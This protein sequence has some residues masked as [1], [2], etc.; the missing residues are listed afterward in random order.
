MLRMAVLLGCVGL[1]F[2]WAGVA[3]ART[4]KCTTGTITISDTN[5][6]T[7]GQ[8]CGGSVTIPAG[9]TSIND[10]AFDTAEMLK[11]VIIP[12]SVTTVG[13][14][15]FNGAKLLTGVTFEFPSAVTSIGA[16]AFAYTDLTSI[17]IPDS[18]K[19][20]G[21]ATFARSGSLRS[22]YFEGNAPRLTNGSIFLDNSNVMVYRFSRATGFDPTI[23]DTVDVSTIVDTPFPARTPAPTVLKRDILMHYA[24][25]TVPEAAIGPKPTSFLITE[26]PGGKMCSTAGLSMN[27]GHACM[28]LG[29]DR[30]TTYTFTAVAINAKGTSATSAPSQEAPGV[31]IAS[32][33]AQNF[34]LADPTFNQADQVSKAALQAALTVGATN[35]RITMSVVLDQRGPQAGG[36]IIAARATPRP[37]CHATKR[38]KLKHAGTVRLTCRYTKAARALL[39][40]HAITVKVVVSFKPK[41]GSRKTSTSLLTL[42]RLH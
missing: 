34:L 16:T 18:V 5:S 37:L 14:S 39:R 20:M 8:G 23:W 1:V 22:V 7:D 21:V 10:H 36:P 15:A 30:S 35:G 3:S 9:V 2:T 31:Y 17:T 27:N 13:A 42:K 40:R 4:V 26:H 24:I 29:L 12:S 41:K 33:A 19:T 6:V 28:V 32:E 11:S 38:I 25:V